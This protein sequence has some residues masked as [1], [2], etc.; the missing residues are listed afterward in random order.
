MMYP[1]V[2]GGKSSK[3]LPYNFLPGVLDIISPTIKK[4]ASSVALTYY[5]HLKILQILYRFYK[6]G[7]DTEPR[8]QMDSIRSP[9]KLLELCL[10]ST[11]SPSGPSSR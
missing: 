2:I 7:C 9:G 3:G 11:W 6:R 8:I 1:Y 4:T 5:S 10:E